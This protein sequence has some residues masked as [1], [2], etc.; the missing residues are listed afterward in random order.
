MAQIIAHAHLEEARNFNT[1]ERKKLAKTGSALPDGSFPIKNAEDLKNAI[2]L[3]GKA[4]NIA[5]A[6]AHIKRRAKVLAL[7]NMI[8]AGW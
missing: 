3:A 4:K 8:P 7:T 1:P 6:K 5:A 2:K